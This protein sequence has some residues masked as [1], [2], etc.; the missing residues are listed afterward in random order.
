M[1][2]FWIGFTFFSIL[3]LFFILFALSIIKQDEEKEKQLKQNLN[4]T[5]SH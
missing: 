4:K 2:G 5:K 3:S 1:S